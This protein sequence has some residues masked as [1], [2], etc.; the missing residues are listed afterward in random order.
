MQGEAGIC[1]RVEVCVDVCLCVDTCVD[2]CVVMFVT[3][4]QNKWLT[5]R[6]SEQESK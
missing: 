1:L 2:T 5:V 4:E 3:D 6:A